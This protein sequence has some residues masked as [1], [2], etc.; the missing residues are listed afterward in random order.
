MLAVVHVNGTNTERVPHA[1]S[2]ENDFE[3]M[4]RIP[5]QLDAR[6]L[7]WYAL[8]AIPLLHGHTE[9]SVLREKVSRIMQSCQNCS[10]TLGTKS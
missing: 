4:E 5:R 2:N 9:G 3:R 1:S 10:T 7:K 8:G 6:A